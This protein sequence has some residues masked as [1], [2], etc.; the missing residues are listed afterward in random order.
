MAGVPEE[1]LFRKVYPGFLSFPWVSPLVVQ[2]G[3][4]FFG[5]CTRRE[6]LRM[7]ETSASAVFM[8]LY[9]WG[10]SFLTM[11]TAPLR[12]LSFRST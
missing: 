11:V 9:S 6:A 5:P 12:G 7:H 1:K 10:D 8:L 2:F 4:G 3:R